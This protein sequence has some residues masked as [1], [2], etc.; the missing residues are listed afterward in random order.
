M[1]NYKRSELY[2]ENDSLSVL[3]GATVDIITVPIPPH[4]ML[5]LK[6]FGNYL[7]AVGAWSFVTWR[8]KHNG[9]TLPPYDAILDQIGYAAQREKIR[10]LELSSGVF[11]I[12]ATNASAGAVSIGVSLEYELVYQE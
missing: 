11:A 9:R 1:D 10:E 12:E 5:R 4:C 2:A 3:A 7:G 8:F 6:K